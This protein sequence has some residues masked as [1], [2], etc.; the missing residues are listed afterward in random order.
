MQAYAT[1]V[2]GVPRKKSVYRIA[3]P[4]SGFAPRPGNPLTIART[5][6]STSTRASAITI[7]W[8]LIRKPDQMSGSA[9]RNA[10]GSA[11]AWRTRC[12]VLSCLLQHGDLR[13]IDCEPLLLQLADR[14]VRR[15]GLDR[16]RDARRQLGSLR[17]HGAILLVGHD[18]TSD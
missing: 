4:R 11:N 8:T 18:L 15:Q 6:A 17:K 3:R 7:M 16:A 10:N 12:I 13:D 1:I 14:A 9:W 5:S 2:S